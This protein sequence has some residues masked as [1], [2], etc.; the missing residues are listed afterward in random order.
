MAILTETMAMN[1][2]SLHLKAWD[3][4]TLSLL[5][6]AHP[7]RNSNGRSKTDDLTAADRRSKQEVARELQHPQPKIWQTYLGTT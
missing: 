6:R 5:E 4:T 7:M 2:R 1:S 3:P